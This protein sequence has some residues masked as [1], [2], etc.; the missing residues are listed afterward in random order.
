M[1]IM[2]GKLHKYL[3]M[4]IDYSS[5]GKLMFSMINYI[6]K[7]LD[8]IPEDMKGVSA[9]PAAYHLFYIAEDATKPSQAG[10]DLFHHFVSQLL[11][12]FK[13]GTSIHP[14]SSILPVKYSERY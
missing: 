12:L 14:D 11:Y 13:E 6:G 9:T 4:T 8:N 7:I 1:T 3:G 5:P 10:A 2:R